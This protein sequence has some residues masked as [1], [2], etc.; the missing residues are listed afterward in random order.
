MDSRWRMNCGA[1]LRSRSSCWSS[2]PIGQ[3]A[4]AGKGANMEMPT[5]AEF[6]WRMFELLSSKCCRGQTT[7][8]F[9][10]AGKILSRGLHKLLHYRFEKLVFLHYKL[11]WSGQGVGLLLLLLLLLLLV[12]ADAI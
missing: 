5:G 7:W 1:S 8:I 6:F 2:P 9:S 3:A 11:K 12:H 4:L 10:F